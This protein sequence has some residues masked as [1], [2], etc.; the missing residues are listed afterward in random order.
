M[1]HQ[2]KV[3][4][5][6]HIGEDAACLYPLLLDANSVYISDEA[7]YHYR[8][9]TD[10]LIKT[11]DPFE[12]MKLKRFVGFLVRVSFK[13]VRAKFIKSAREVCRQL[14]DCTS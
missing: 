2:L 1:H 14:A 3:D 13:S 11:R 12:V 8:Q 6:I 4:D 10:S 7:F 5:G 9:R